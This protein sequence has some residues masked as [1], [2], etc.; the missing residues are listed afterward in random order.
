MLSQDQASSLYSK[1]SE[2]DKLLQVYKTS[3]FHF[4]TSSAHNPYLVLKFPSVQVGN[5]KGAEVYFKCLIQ[6]K[7]SVRK[8]HI[9]SCRR[10]RNG[11][12]IN[13]TEV[14]G[15][16]LL[17]YQFWELI[18]Q[19]PQ[20]TASQFKTK[21]QR[22]LPVRHDSSFHSD[23]GG[24]EM[25]DLLTQ[26]PDDPMDT[27]HQDQG[28]LAG[29]KHLQCGWLI[30]YFL[31]I[32]SADKAP[33]E[34]RQIKML[35]QTQKKN[36]K[37]N[38]RFLKKRPGK[39]IK[40]CNS[41]L[42]LLHFLILEQNKTITPLGIRGSRDAKAGLSMLA[43][44]QPPWPRH[45]KFMD[46]TCTP[47]NQPFS[48]LTQNISLIF[49]ACTVFFFPFFLATESQCKCERLAASKFTVNNLRELWIARTLGVRS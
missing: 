31:V 26:G 21:V 45:S 47:V 19:P 35:N 14:Y 24:W 23:Q 41:Q 49:F 17:F 48:E 25:K 32:N 28:C 18:S 43:G 37:I 27:A 6:V 12:P 39:I 42:Q 46:R 3:H 1:A 9:S 36:L 7:A 38:L 33:T 2:T 16:F 44:W 30:L 4:L 8:I 29:N 5:P 20:G 15:L 10:K 40:A 11:S 13:I 22:P 34:G